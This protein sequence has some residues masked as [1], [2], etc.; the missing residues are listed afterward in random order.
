LPREQVPS[1]GLSRSSFLTALSKR[2]SEAA[3]TIHTE[4]VVSTLRSFAGQV[5]AQNISSVINGYAVLEHLPEDSLTHAFEQRIQQ[6]AADMSP[7]DIAAVLAS[8]A[9]LWHM[10][11]SRLEGEDRSRGY[12]DLLERLPGESALDYVCRRAEHETRGRGERLRCLCTARAD[13]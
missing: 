3:Q 13:A 9:K 11:L 1:P 5:N 8:Y 10:R 4:D 2:A 12:E 7:S 6:V